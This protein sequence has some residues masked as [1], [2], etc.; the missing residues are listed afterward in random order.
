MGVAGSIFEPHPPNF[1]KSDIFLRSTNGDTI[2]FRNFHYHKSYKK[3][4]QPIR[5]GVEES[6]IKEIEACVSTTTECLQTATLTPGSFAAP[7]N[8]NMQS[9][10]FES[11][12]EGP[13]DFCH[14]QNLA[15]LL[16]NVIFA[17]VSL[18]I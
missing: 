2:I 7:C 8:E 5:P 17:Q 6:L 11:P 14:V 13:I 9:F 16:S 15:A 18:F 4:T 3:C 1:G 10:S 12:D